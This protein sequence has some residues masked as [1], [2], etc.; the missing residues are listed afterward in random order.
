MPKMLCRYQL[1]MRW[2]PKKL[3]HFLKVKKRLKLEKEIQHGVVFRGNF[4]RLNLPKL[5]KLE[6]YIHRM[7]IICHK[8]RNK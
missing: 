4:K 3:C 1:R 8:N 5:D 6:N 2:K 7:L